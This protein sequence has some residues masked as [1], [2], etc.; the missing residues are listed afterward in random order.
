M[1]HDISTNRLLLI[2]CIGA[3]RSIR[4]GHDLIGDDHR[5]AELRFRPPSVRNQAGGGKILYLVCQP[6]QSA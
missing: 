6:L 1:S 2:S 3:S 5:N 4:V